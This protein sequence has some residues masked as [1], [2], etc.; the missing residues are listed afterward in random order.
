MAQEKHEALN[1]GDLYQDVAKSHG[2]EVKQRQGALAAP[3]MQG[4]RQQQEGEDGHDRDEEHD[5]QDHDT[6]VHFP[7]DAALQSAI[8]KNLVRLQGE[9]KEWGVVVDRRDVV[10]IVA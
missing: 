7:I 6:E 8:V 5:S 3:A 9:K 2:D 4:H 10:G 1:E